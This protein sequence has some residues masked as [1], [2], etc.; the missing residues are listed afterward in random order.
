MIYLIIYAIGA[1]LSLVLIFTI[2]RKRINPRVFNSR[3]DMIV[4]ILWF[5]FI[6]PVLLPA[7]AYK[8]MRKDLNL[9]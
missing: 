3:R 5:I 6:W 2:F 8:W 4:T 7:F 9:F 1:I